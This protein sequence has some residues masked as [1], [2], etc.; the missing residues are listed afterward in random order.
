MIRIDCHGGQIGRFWWVNSNRGGVLRRFGCCG[1]DE[2]WPDRQPWPIRPWGRGDA[3]DDFDMRD[4]TAFESWFDCQLEVRLLDHID[5]NISK[6]IEFY[7]MLCGVFAAG[8]D[9]GRNPWSWAQHVEQ[10]QTRAI[11]EDQ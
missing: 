11:Q 9:A 7:N 5:L 8:I 10:Q 4:F 1:W 6:K 3:V 2:T